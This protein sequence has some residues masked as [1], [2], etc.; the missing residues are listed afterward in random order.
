M[1]DKG[2]F[3]VDPF[4][5][6][7]SCIHTCPLSMAAPDHAAA[8]R[9]PSHTHPC[10]FHPVKPFPPPLRY[11]D[12]HYRA[13]TWRK[14]T[15]V[16]KIVD[17]GFNVMHSDVDVVWFRDPLPY[18]L[19]EPCKDIDVAIS[20]GEVP[21]SKDLLRSDLIGLAPPSHC[22]TAPPSSSS[23]V[24]TALHSH[25]DTAS[26]LLPAQPSPSITL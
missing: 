4:Q 18:F 21:G 8:P 7:P 9:Y 11:G 17:W 16:E 22:G 24:S 2:G 23:L 20:T 10:Y 3:P 5:P 19:G 13:A 12:D 6:Y 25:C 14:V 15:V 26:L 1:E